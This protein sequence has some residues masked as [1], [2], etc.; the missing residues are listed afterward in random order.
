MDVDSARGNPVFV[1]Y[2]GEESAAWHVAVLMAMTVGYLV[3][4]A[5][6]LRIR[7]F[8]SAAETDS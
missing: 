8:T 1:A 6:L 4:A 2:F 5:L 7:E 3:A